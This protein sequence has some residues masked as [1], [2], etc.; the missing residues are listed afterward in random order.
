MKGTSKE[1]E[2]Y[3]KEFAMTASSRHLYLVMTEHTFKVLATPGSREKSTSFEA[4][5]N[6]NNSGIHA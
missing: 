4:V 6:R 1:L 3:F 2:P 5:K